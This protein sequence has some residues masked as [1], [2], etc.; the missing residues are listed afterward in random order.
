M[1]YV[2]YSENVVH[3]DFH[4][5]DGGRWDYSWSKTSEFEVV[6]A[7]LNK[8]EGYE[9]ETFSLD[10]QLGEEAFVFSVIYSD[11]DTFGHSVGNGEVVWVFKTKEQ[12]DKAETLFWEN[13]K[14]YSIEFENEDGEKITLSNPGSGYFETL[15]EVRIDRAIVQQ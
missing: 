6:G 13:R 10:F 11:G 14:A 1:I 4:Q 3:E 12:A 8:P 2:K 7:F 9:Y 5:G 15:D